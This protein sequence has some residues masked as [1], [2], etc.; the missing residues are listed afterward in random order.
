MSEHQP[1]I[2]EWYTRGGDIFEV[3][4]VDDSDG[5]VE[6]QHFDGTV[7]EFD[8]DEWM[9]QR[10]RGEIEDGEAPEDPNGSFDVDSENDE[11]Q[12]L[13]PDLDNDRRSMSGPLDGLDL[14]E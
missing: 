7:E 11:S 6:V 5:T 8:I 4:A 10:A 12:N 1:A 13:S 14:F 2:G 9:A 3:V